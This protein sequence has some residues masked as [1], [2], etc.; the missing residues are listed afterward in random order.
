MV[1]EVQTE[2]YS[3]YEMAKLI[4]ARAL[5]I[6]MGAPFMLNLTD[7]DLQ[8]I[9]YNPIKIAKLEIEAGV[10]PISIVRGEKA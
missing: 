8:K 7:K 6:S 10:V 2:N 3:K 4:G 1:K 5:Q 9:G